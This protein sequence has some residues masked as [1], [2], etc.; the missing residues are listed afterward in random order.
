MIEIFKVRENLKISKK[1]DLEAPKVL[2]WLLRTNRCRDDFA[3][4]S[5]QTVID[6]TYCE[7]ARTII[8]SL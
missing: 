1:N 2:N 6:E 4:F 3:V 8:A 7:F 5:L